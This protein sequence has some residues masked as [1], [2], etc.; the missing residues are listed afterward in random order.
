MDTGK[1]ELGVE[2][3]GAAL[4]LT[5][6]REERRNAMSHAV[7]AALGDAIAAAQDDRSVRAPM[8][9]LLW[10]AAN[11][12]TGRRAALATPTFGK[13]GTSQNNRDALFVGY[14]AAMVTGAI[15]LR[16]TR[17]MYALSGATLRR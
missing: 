11:D 2:R 12:G 17:S 8:L 3:R 9:D 16:V 15:S 6:Q 14:T 7:L 10:A 13:T 4:W 1:A 5:I